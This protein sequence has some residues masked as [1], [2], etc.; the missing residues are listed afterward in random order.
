VLGRKNWLKL[1]V[2]LGLFCGKLHILF[3]FATV[4]VEGITLGLEASESVNKERTP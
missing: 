3:V 4:W 2:P 1:F